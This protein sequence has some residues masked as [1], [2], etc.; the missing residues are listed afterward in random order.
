MFHILVG[1][2]KTHIKLML[3]FI[4]KSTFNVLVFNYFNFMV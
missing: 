1:T 2:Y 3:H 4:T